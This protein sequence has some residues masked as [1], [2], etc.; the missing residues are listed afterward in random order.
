MLTNDLLYV[1]K[2]AFN[3]TPVV[4]LRSE[5]VARLE[6]CD[7]ILIHGLDISWW[8]T[9]RWMMVTGWRVMTIVTRECRSYHQ[10]NNKKGIEVHSHHVF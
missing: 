9:F 2:A 3:F 10:K 5:R 4:R 7:P 8:F 6:T 1:P